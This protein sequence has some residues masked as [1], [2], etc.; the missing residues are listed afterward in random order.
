M[1]VLA[2]WSATSRTALVFV[3][4]GPGRDVVGGLFFPREHIRLVNQYLEYG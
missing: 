1:D 4:E 3:G 2:S